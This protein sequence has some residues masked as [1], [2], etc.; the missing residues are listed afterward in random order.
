MDINYRLDP[1]FDDPVTVWQEFNKILSPME[2]QN[3]ERA[4]VMMEADKPATAEMHRRLAG[5]GGLR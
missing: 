1:R 2:W 5:Y 3:I 4:A